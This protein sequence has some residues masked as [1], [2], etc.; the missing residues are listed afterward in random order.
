M[1]IIKSEYKALKFRAMVS[2]LRAN[3]FQIEILIISL[4]KQ[5]LM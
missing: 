2:L 5:D 3:L 4:R 1:S